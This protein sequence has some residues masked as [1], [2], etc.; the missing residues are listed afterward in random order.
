MLA[1]M[2]AKTWHLLRHYL[3]RTDPDARTELVTDV[4]E[5]S[6]GYVLQKVTDGTATPLA[7]WSKGPT[8]SQKDWSTVQRKLLACHLFCNI[9]DAF[10]KEP[11]LFFGLTIVQSS[12]SSK[13][14]LEML[15][16]DRK[17]VVIARMNHPVKHDSGNIKTKHQ[18]RAIK[19]DQLCA[20]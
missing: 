10:W 18:T 13:N 7:L 8:R 5:V 2:R 17:V 15:H 20:T 9:L 11:T 3:L 19:K 1:L 6:V 16:P 12:P 14:I 4:S